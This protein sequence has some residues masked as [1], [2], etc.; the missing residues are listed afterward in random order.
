MSVRSI[1]RVIFAA[2]LSVG[3]GVAALANVP[4]RDAK[5]IEPLKIHRTVQ[6]V[7]PPMLSRR[8]VDSGEARVLIMV[9]REGRLADWMI[10]GY[11]HAPFAKEALDVIQKWKFE[12]ATYRGE[13][14][15]ARAELR[16]NFRTE[17]I[18]RMV[19]ADM[20]VETK[21][22][23]AT[24]RKGFWQRYCESTDLDKIPDTIV[25][26]NPMPP[27]RLGAV[28][29]E[30]NVVVDYYIDP[31]G[32][33]RMPIILSSDDDAFS[34]SVLLAM[35][36]WRYEIPRRQNIPVMTRMW[37]QFHFRSLRTAQK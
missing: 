2:V 27:D 31:E 3:G 35:S 37:R 10:T 6:P 20:V 5:D 24:A 17:G 34:Q 11:S 32:R 13:P 28:A 9:D 19:P 8:M 29:S 23:D 18:I 22:R 16:F 36:D 30:G 7:F 26:I 25:E 15:N 4:V 33:V 21:I 14:I 12:P 1:T